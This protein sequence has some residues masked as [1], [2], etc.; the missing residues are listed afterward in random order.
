[1]RSLSTN[2]RTVFTWAG[3]GGAKPSVQV[4]QRQQ[5]L[6]GGDDTDILQDAETILEEEGEELLVV[7]KVQL[8]VATGGVV[9]TLGE[10][11]LDN[12]LEDNLDPLGLVGDKCLV[13]RYVRMTK[14]LPPQVVGE[15]ID[16]LR[17]MSGE[18]EKSVEIR[19]NVGWIARG[20][21]GPEIAELLPKHSQYL[22]HFLQKVVVITVQF[23][24]LS[25]LGR[26]KQLTHHVGLEQAEEL[27]SLTHLYN[28][29]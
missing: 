2:Q 4:H 6:R 17:R 22:D 12:L 21:F 27:G 28:N 1:M 29:N 3:Q 15:K 18:R 5:G 20:V 11:H 7:V 23:V 10:A 13:S 26:G 16:G 19:L 9:V 8:T 25:I 24:L 14:E